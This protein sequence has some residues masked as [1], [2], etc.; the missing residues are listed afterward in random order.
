MERLKALVFQHV[1]NEH[2]G[3]MGP[4]LER[5][6]IEVS[7]INFSKTPNLPKLYPVELFDLLVVLGGPMGANDPLSEY[8][9]RTVEIGTIKR[10]IFDAK[11]PVLGIC[12]GSQLIARA[13]GAEVYQNKK[14]GK[15][16]KEIGYYGVPLTKIGLR[17]AVFSGLE[18]PLSALQWHGD[19]FELPKGAKRLAT[20]LHCSN[21]A[22]VY[23]KD[24]ALAYGVLFHFEFTPDM[25]RQQIEND[26]LWIHDHDI[27][28]F[29]VNEEELI[30]LA[31]KNSKEMQRE[32]EI[33]TGNIVRITRE[34]KLA[35]AA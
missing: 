13:L 29:D 35:L 19:A 11:V 32:C 27:K 9:S 15:R 31:D 22:F 2:L 23:T 4:A 17:D 20:S 14:Y 12:L 6:G 7:I 24:G 1:D 10:A 34:R 28:G 3:Y 30:Y 25:V 18:S 33:F 21:Q 26:R 5:Q 8:S 16:I